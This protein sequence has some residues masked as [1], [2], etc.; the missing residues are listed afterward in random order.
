MHDHSLLPTRTVTMDANVTQSEP[1]RS[2][3]VDALSGPVAAQVLPEAQAHTACT[4]ATGQKR[5]RQPNIAPDSQ[6][7]IG[8]LHDE[9]YTGIG[10]ASK[11]DP[12]W[13]TIRDRAV[14][15]LYCVPG[16]G[17][18]TVRTAVRR[19]RGMIPKSIASV[20]S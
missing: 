18:E 6:A 13:E 8:R 4:I 7:N 15:L 9:L 2:D 12:V 19:A 11:S 20:M 3:A 5:T 14:E 1:T 16:S 10:V 17:T